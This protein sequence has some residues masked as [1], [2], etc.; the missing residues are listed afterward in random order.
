M[1]FFR[2][3]ISARRRVSAVVWKVFRNTPIQ[4]LE[5]NGLDE[6]FVSP[7]FKRAC[8]VVGRVLSRD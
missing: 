1:P 5:A 6:E 2:A 4:R 7:G 3:L 8:T